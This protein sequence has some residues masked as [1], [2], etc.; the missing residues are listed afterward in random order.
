M[1]D[2][3]AAFPFFFFFILKMKETTCSEAPTRKS[4]FYLNSYKMVYLHWIT[5]PIDHLQKK[6][7]R[8]HFTSWP[9]KEK[10]LFSFYAFRFDFLCEC[11]FSSLSYL[12]MSYLFIEFIK[13]S[14]VLK[15]S[16]DTRKLVRYPI[17]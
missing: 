4:I 3:R 13:C 14:V 15:I 1:D 10:D 9:T 11:I 17:L 5:K 7:V 16:R 8:L 12:F 2:E 6:K